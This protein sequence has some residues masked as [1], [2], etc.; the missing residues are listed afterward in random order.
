MFAV[1]FNHSLI[2]YASIEE[3]IEA[4][5]NKSEPD[6]SHLLVYRIEVVGVVNPVQPLTGDGIDPNGGGT[7]VALRKAA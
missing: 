4:N 6:G 1:A 2:T 3:A 7:P 5:K